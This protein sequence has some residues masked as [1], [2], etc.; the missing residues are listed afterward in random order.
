[1]RARPDTLA[2]KSDAPSS[3]L[4]T[5]PESLKLKVWSKSLTNR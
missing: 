5:I 2:S 4:S 3:S 1:M